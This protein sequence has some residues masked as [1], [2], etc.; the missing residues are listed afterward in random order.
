MPSL[1]SLVTHA[2]L[3]DYPGLTL[4]R[5]SISICKSL[6][7]NLVKQVWDTFREACQNHDTC[8]IDIRKAGKRFN[9]KVEQQLEKYHNKD[10]FINLETELVLS[11]FCWQ[12]LHSRIKFLLNKKL[13]S[14]CFS[15]L[16]PSCPSFQ[17]P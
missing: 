10:C 11:F 13:F 17:E 6:G 1:H 12:F 14:V 16:D 4:Q 2:F 7:L 9:G 15:K 8:F 3:Y 5:L